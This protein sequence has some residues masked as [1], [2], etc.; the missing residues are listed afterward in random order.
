M[1]GARLILNT[2]YFHIARAGEQA[3]WKHVMTKNSAIG[4]V[5]YVGARKSVQ[6]N[7]PNQL[8]LP[9]TNWQSPRLPRR[10]ELY[11]GK[12]PAGYRHCQRKNFQLHLQ[13]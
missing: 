6:L 11:L 3:D 2:R 9:E 13:P 10:H 5:N 8:S 12:P 4:V 7:M 1:P